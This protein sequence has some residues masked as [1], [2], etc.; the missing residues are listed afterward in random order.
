[1]FPGFVHATVP[2][3]V[4]FVP[5]VAFFDPVVC[6]VSD[7][8]QAEVAVNCPLLPIQTV[9]PVVVGDVFTVTVTLP[10][11]PQHPALVT[12]LK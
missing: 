7:P 4:T 10:C 12:A 6:P 11:V 3:P 5:T 1:M 9:V 8:L 2:T